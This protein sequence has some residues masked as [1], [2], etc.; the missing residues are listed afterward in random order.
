MT[1]YYVIKQRLLLRPSDLE[2]CSETEVYRRLKKFGYSSKLKDG[3]PQ[4]NITKKQI[5]KMNLQAH[6][7]FM[8]KL[9]KNLETKKRYDTR[10]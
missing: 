6:E 4:W 2:P 8:S 1:I 5:E 7:E 9:E 10:H 3:K